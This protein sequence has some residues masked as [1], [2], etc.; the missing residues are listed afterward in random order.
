MNSF[1]IEG[2]FVLYKSEAGLA[3]EKK[4]KVLTGPE[5]G[6]QDLKGLTD[7]QN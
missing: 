4:M 7:N 2:I 1:V 5:R 6:L 3:P